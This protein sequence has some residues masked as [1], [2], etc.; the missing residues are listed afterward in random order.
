MAA[1]DIGMV[2]VQKHTEG[3]DACPY[4]ARLVQFYAVG[5]GHIFSLPFGI[6]SGATIFERGKNLRMSDVV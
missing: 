2:P 4:R 5:M 3:K 1:R 6:P